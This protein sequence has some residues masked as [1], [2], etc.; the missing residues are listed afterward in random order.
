MKQRNKRQLAVVAKRAKKR[1]NAKPTG[2]D[3]GKQG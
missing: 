2:A 3:A 1:R